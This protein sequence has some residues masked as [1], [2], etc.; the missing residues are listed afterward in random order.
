MNKYKNKYRIQS[1]RLQNWN[2]GSAGLYFITICTY[3]REHYFGE[4]QNG[5]MN[6]NSMGLITVD[7]W[8]K[9]PSNRPDMNLELGEFV[10]MPNHF[11]GIVMIG[12]NIFNSGGHDDEYGRD[13]MHRVSET[14]TPKNKF[15]PNQKTWVR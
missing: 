10:V 9:T 14:T 3:I 8:N 1:A 5:V 2:Y 13:A 12:A 7:E 11:H 15:G 6:L 4:I